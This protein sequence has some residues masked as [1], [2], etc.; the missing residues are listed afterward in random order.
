MRGAL[1]RSQGTDRDR[2]SEKRSG[3]NFIGYIRKG[4]AAGKESG[5]KDRR[6]GRELRIQSRKKRLVPISEKE[7]ET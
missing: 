5:Q 7:S 3:K 2:K 4:R 1:E 6:Q